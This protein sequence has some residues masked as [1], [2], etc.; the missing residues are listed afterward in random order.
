MSTTHNSP[1][2][3]NALAN[4]SSKFRS[5]VIITYLE[6]KFRYTKSHHNSEFDSLGISSGKFCETVLRFL[7]YEL[8]GAY[9]PF[10]Q[11]IKNFSDEVDKL[12]RTDKTKGNDSTRILIPKALGLIYTI[13]NKRGIGHVGGDIEANKIDSATIVR[14]VDWALCELIRIYHN[15]SIEEAQ[16]IIDT[17]ATR[18]LPDVWEVNGKKRILR[19]DLDFKQQVL[20]LVYSE[21][22]NGVAIEDLFSWTQYSSASMFKAKVILPLHRDKYI[23]YDTETKYVHISPLGIHEVENSVLLKKSFLTK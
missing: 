2:L 22:Q 17:L 5:R 19:K 20:L 6:L 3:E 11:Q 9:I 14:V 21:T 13:R 15:L 8:T 1:E 23:E 18:S 4:L 12:G 7:Q 16:D 10:V